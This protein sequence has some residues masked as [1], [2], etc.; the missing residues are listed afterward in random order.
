MY[1][2]LIYIISYVL[3]TGLIFLSAMAA[4]IVHSI[5]DKDNI[6]PTTLV[7]LSICT[8]LLGCMLIVVSRL[9]LA[10]VIQVCNHYPLTKHILLNTY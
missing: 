10:T 6:V 2:I 8:F 9:K 3:S 4:S 5:E 1:Y 7:V